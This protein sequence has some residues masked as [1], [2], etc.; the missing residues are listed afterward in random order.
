MDEFLGFSPKNGKLLSAPADVALDKVNRNGKSYMYFT[1]LNFKIQTNSSRS[2][3]RDMM[4]GEAL[5]LRPRKNE[6]NSDCLSFSNDP[7]GKSAV[8]CDVGIGFTIH[9]PVIRKSGEALG[10]LGQ[11]QGEIR[12]RQLRTWHPRLDG[13]RGTCMYVEKNTTAP[14]A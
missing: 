7:T 11:I 14:A 5:D 12:M 3:T 1:W 10:I 6:K 8:R 9:R 2:L 13:S 4:D